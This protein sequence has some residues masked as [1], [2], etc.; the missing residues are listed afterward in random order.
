MLHNIRTLSQE[1]T[2]KP[3][4]K[5][6][7]VPPVTMDVFTMSFIYYVLKSTNSNV[8]IYLHT[9]K[10][11]EY[12]PNPT[13][14]GK[15]EYIISISSTKSRLN[16]ERRRLQHF[17]ITAWATNPKQ[18]TNAIEFLTSALTQHAKKIST[19]YQDANDKYRKNNLHFVNLSGYF[20]TTVCDYEI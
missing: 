15:A 11:S 14:I 12:V 16:K 4:Y 1:S 3:V 18:L 17:S 8:K 5:R 10:Q 6:R 9:D 19:S 2:S 20:T 7:E 13:S